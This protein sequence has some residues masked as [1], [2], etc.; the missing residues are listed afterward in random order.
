MI[1]FKVPVIVEGKYDKA[2]L[3]SM[4]SSTIITTNGFGVFK[5]PE[6][7]A[8]I[9]KEEKAFFSWTAE[10]EMPMDVITLAY[11][12]TVARTGEANIS[13]TNAILEKWNAQGLRTL[14]DVNAAEEKRKNSPGGV[15]GSSFDTEDFFTSALKRSYEN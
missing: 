13:Y 7:R 6:K 14:D 2:R 15:S 11:E 10:W 1:S 12:I 8:L 5:N 4:V 3:A 9:K